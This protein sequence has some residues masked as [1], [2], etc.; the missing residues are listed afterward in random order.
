[1]VVYVLV[2][3]VCFVLNARSRT[4]SV[5]KVIKIF[6]ICKSAYFFL[7]FLFKNLHISIKCR[8]FAPFLLPRWWNR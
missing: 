2:I 1:M 4:F 7:R 5:A 3:I 6:D 8:I